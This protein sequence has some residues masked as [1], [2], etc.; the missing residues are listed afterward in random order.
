MK[1]FK[2]IGFWVCVTASILL[3]SQTAKGWIDD[4]KAEDTTP[5]T[6]VEAVT[7]IVIS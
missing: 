3:I 2:K 4:K 6:G 5:E 1:T 7:D